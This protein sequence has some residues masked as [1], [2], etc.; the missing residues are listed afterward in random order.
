MGAPSNRT[1]TLESQMIPMIQDVPGQ[2]L[3][4]LGVASRP[5]SRERSRSASPPSASIP[6]PRPSASL[7]VRHRYAPTCRKR[8]LW[9]TL[10]MTKLLQ[11][12]IDKVSALPEATQQ[13]IAEDLIAHVE[14]VEHLRTELQKGIISLDRGEGRELDIEHV[15]RTARAAYERN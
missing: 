12:A 8:A 3:S 7:C 1:A 11:E 13:S 15:I 2:T 4:F 5:G 6:D 10:A 14:S 9:Y